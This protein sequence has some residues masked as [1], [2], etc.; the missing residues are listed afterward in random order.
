MD[1][2]RSSN[3]K[4]VPLEIA[5]SVEVPSAK[6]LVK[7]RPRKVSPRG[8]ENQVSGSPSGSPI[9]GSSDS[10]YAHGTQSKK[11]TSGR[12]KQLSIS[13]KPSEAEAVVS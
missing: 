11:K 13:S 3:Q 10:P 2:L 12:K 7:K 5:R 4:M 8:S 9:K 6:D 1:N